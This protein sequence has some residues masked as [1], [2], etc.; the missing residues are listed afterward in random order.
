MIKGGSRERKVGRQASNL[1]PLEIR[2]RNQG[3][4]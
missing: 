2:K 1:W 4:T 3:R